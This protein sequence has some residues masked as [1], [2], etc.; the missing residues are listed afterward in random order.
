MDKIICVKIDYEHNSASFYIDDEHLN[1]NYYEVL[2]H[3]TRCKYF[4]DQIDFPNSFCDKSCEFIDYHF[5]TLKCP[6]G[7]FEIVEV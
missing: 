5:C 1:E 7:K 2:K 4:D 6:L 3:C